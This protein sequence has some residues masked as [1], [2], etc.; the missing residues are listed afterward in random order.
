[1]LMNE[2]QQKIELQSAGG[3]EERLLNLQRCLVCYN[4]DLLYCVAASKP[5]TIKQLHPPITVQK[6]D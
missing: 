3:A 5:F 1:M 6:K 4:K 2:R